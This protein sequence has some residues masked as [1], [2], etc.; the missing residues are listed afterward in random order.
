MIYFSSENHRQN[1]E[2]LVERFPKALTDGEYLS[3][4]YVAAFPGVFKCFKLEDQEH[5]PFDWFIRSEGNGAL[6]GQTRRLVELGVNLW[7]GQPV[8]LAD[9]IDVWDDDVF[10]VAMQAIQL[11]RSPTL[12]LGED[13]T[14]CIV[15]GC[16]EEQPCPGGCHWVEYAEGDLC[17]ACY[18]RITA[19]VSFS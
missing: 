1:F 16:T 5:G 17:S 3:A 19:G 9:G 18:E 13:E 8:N 14:R 12:F 7:N 11:R 10:L 2:R 15:C 6:T 4:C